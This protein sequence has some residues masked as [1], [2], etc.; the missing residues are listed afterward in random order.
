MEPE[1]VIK[2]SAAVNIKSSAL[3]G[4]NLLSKKERKEEKHENQCTRRS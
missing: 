3:F 1:K 2:L 4:N